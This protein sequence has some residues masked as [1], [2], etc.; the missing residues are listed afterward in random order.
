[1]LESGEEPV[2]LHDS[3][4]DTHLFVFNIVNDHYRHISHLLATIYVLEWFATTQKKQLIVKYA[5]F[6]LIV[7]QLY[8]IVLH[9]ILYQCVLKHEWPLVLNEAHDHVTR[10]QY[11]WK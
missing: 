10:G 3:I 5:H 1:M 7:R 2:S 8:N 4:P 6:Q 9:E 11:A